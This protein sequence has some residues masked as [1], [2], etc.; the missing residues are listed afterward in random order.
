M[1]LNMLV[2]CVRGRASL[3]LMPQRR[4]AFDHER[5]YVCLLLTRP[6]RVLMTLRVHR[7]GAVV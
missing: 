1:A 2:D 5:C 3:C 4:R 7:L 6:L